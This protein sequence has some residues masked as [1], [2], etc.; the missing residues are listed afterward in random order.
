MGQFLFINGCGLGGRA[1]FDE[2]LVKLLFGAGN[3]QFGL[4]RVGF[5]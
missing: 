4:G 5:E 2:G 1:N 3:K